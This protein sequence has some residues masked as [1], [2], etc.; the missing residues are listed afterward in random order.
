MKQNSSI[1]PRLGRTA[2]LLAL[3]IP[4]SAAV[5]FKVCYT[6]DTNPAAVVGKSGDFLIKDAN[7][8]VTIEGLA[9][10]KVIKKNPSSLEVMQKDK[11][12]IISSEGPCALRIRDIKS[13]IK[14]FTI[15]KDGRVTA[16]PSKPNDG[17]ALYGFKVTPGTGTTLDLISFYTK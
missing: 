7:A 9:T 16:V 2:L 4:L 11:V 15:D 17:Y 8:E 5:K 1:L 3:A 10:Y 6:G 14:N 12:Y 13:K